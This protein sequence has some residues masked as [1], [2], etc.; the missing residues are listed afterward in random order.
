MSNEITFW[1]DIT[2]RPQ[3][4]LRFH[5]RGR[6]KRMKIFP[7][8]P[9]KTKEYQEDIRNR[10]RQWVAREYLH[11]FTKDQALYLHATKTVFPMFSSVYM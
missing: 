5:I 8:I 9:E 4:R 10:A 3:E 2:P 6:G 11:E 7:Y 1:L